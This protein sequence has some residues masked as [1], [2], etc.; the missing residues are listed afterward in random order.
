MEETLRAER[1]ERN[2]EEMR[3]L[4]AKWEQELLQKD[5]ANAEQV[6][7]QQEYF[8]P[9]RGSMRGSWLDVNPGLVLTLGL[10][11]HL[12]QDTSLH[13]LLPESPQSLRL[14]PGT[15]TRHALAAAQVRVLGAQLAAKQAALA[16][17]EVL[18][19]AAGAAAAQNSTMSSELAAKARAL[20]D[21]ER[22][23]AAMRDRVR[24]KE[25]PCF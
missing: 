12:P 22:K 3:A 11:A 1:A 16:E 7:W 18:A 9:G 20:A 23:I 24:P 13:V 21:Q 2:L 25:P 8:D 5:R 17:L 10:Q 6:G 4:Q 19:D 14:N 15:A